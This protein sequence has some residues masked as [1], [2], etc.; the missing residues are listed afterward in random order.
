MRIVQYAYFI[1]Y[2]DVYHPDEISARLGVQPD[3]ISWRASKSSDPP[4]PVTNMWQLNPKVSGTIDVMVEDLV[5]RLEP[6]G[7]QIGALT[8][9][10]ASKIA[11]NVVRRF[12]DPDGV[13]DDDGDLR[14]GLM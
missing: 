2:S 5:D 10:D 13:D 9:R 3:S 1:V 4:R 6:L 11:I 8:K 7:K 14:G 12:D